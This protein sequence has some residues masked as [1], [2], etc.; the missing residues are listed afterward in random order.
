VASENRWGYNDQLKACPQAG[1]ANNKS[2]TGGVAMVLREAFIRTM[3]PALLLAAVVAGNA[4]AQTASVSID[5][6]DA[7][8]PVVAGTNLSYTITVSNE[9]PDSAANVVVTD[10]LPAGTTFVS[11]SMPGGW[12]CAVP[13][14]GATGT[15]TCGKPSVAVGSEA[16]TLIVKV[17]AS[18]QG[19]TLIANS[20][21]VSS[22]TADPNINDNTS[23]RSTQVTALAN[24]S[25]TKQGSPSPVTAGTN[26]SYVITAGNAGPSDA[27]A[28]SWSDT[29][30][31]ATT[32][33]SLASPAGWNCSTPAV[34]SGG[35]VSCTRAA[36][37]PG[38]A[39]FT[40]IVGVPSSVAGG[41][42]LS[43]TATL[44]S[45]TPDSSAGND[46]ATATSTVAAVADLSVIKQAGANPVPAGANLTYN[47]TVNNVGPSNAANAS[48]SDP[49]P[50]GTTFVSLAAPA[51]WVCQTPAIGSG[52]TLTCSRTSAPPGG[53]AFTLVV[54][55][56]AVRGGTV[57]SNTATV[58]SA[59]T[60][61]NS[62]GNTSTA[63][64]TV[65]SRA[66]VSGIKFVSGLFARSGE[67][68]YTIVLHNA[69][70]ETQW[71]NP[72]DEFIDVLPSGLTLLDASA[73][74]GTAL[75]TPG[76]NTVTW[77][78]SIAAGASVTLTIH[79][80]IAADASIGQT[81]S[82]QGHIAYD[83]DGDGINEASAVT[84]DL[85]GLPRATVFA[86]PASP[87]DIP[88]LDPYLLLLLAV[89]LACAAM[90]RRRPRARP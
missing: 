73:T 43:N 63:T 18:V 36:F 25:V 33:V 55:V 6:L 13:A 15:M 20:A 61:P 89:L 84:D 53:N 72:G 27:A 31:G 21:T 82:N 59:T 28:A 56:P 68:T 32:F 9:G 71:D 26:L 4:A 10:P 80:L 50:A 40:L 19:G 23:S 35:T 1:N 29:L 7:P 45:A 70:P 77:N 37:A 46:A 22:T 8:N 87:V 69:G 16:F 60:D 12:N 88:A 2:Q 11:L 83:A 78:G 66:N 5:K 34:G 67:V 86:L 74:S 75:A 54:N 90:Y 48:L 24:L 44:S 51:G 49:L 3:M 42:V 30:P 76:N 52:G 65:I 79:A 38:S 57:L 81:F 39:Q 41:T 47:I 64:V 62:S 17:A 85:T 58:S 14:V